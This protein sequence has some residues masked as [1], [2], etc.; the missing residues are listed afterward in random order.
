MSDGGERG[1]FGKIIVTMNWCGSVKVG[2]VGCMRELSDR[3]GEL[4]VGT[5]GSRDRKA[6]PK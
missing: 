3:D 1:E 5:Y 6:V 2:V 4:E